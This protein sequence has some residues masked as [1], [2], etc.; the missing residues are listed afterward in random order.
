MIA[1]ILNEALQQIEQYQDQELSDSS[2]DF[3]LE[4]LKSHMMWVRYVWECPT[5][6]DLEKL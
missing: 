2:L 4:E 3:F 1:D 5:L 6:D